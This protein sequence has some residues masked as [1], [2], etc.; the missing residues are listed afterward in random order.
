VALPFSYSI[1]AM[2]LL[3]EISASVLGRR[4]PT[5]E[6]SRDERSAPEPVL[7]GWRHIGEARAR[8]SRVDATRDRARQHVCRQRTK[9]RNRSEIGTFSDFNA[10][11]KF[12]K[13]DHPEELKSDLPPSVKS[14]PNRI[15]GW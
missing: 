4:A 12:Y 2:R 15:I 10:L 6:N 3:D 5:I 9:R 14:G 1:D 11:A 7:P 8:C 13:P